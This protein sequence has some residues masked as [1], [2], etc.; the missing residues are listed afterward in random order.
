MTVSRRSL[1]KGI[2]GV[3]QYDPANDKTFVYVIVGFDSEWSS[4]VPKSFTY[5][6]DMNDYSLDSDPGVMDPENRPE[7]LWGQCT[8]TDDAGCPAIQ[9]G[10][11]PMVIRG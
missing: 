2:T 1:M 11:T 10:S 4:G 7:S 8:V 5:T 9:V 3:Q 6:I